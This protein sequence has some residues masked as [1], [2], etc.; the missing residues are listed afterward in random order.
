MTIDPGLLTF[1]IPSSSTLEVP[2]FTY[3]W[4]GKLTTDFGVTYT[5]PTT[6]VISIAAAET[7]TL[8]VNDVC[9]GPCN[10]EYQ[11]VE[12]FY[13]PAPSPNT[14][15]LASIPAFFSGMDTNTYDPLDVFDTET[16]ANPLPITAI[17]KQKRL[18]TVFNETGS[19]YVGPDGFI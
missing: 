3:T 8:G 17:P 11:R 9:C 5:A 7:S 16:A 14:A 10:L 19:T 18:H 15:C 12:V 2:G 6:A 13:W 1:F 4:D